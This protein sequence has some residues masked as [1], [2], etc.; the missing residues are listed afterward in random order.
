M[1][2][3]PLDTFVYRIAYFV[4]GPTWRFFYRIRVVGVENFPLTGP[5]V[6]ACNHRAMTDPF[7]LGSNAPRQIHYMAK[8]ELWKFKPLAWAMERFGTFPVNRGEVDR[9]AIKKAIEILDDGEVLGLFPE[10]HCNKGPGL[11]DLRAGVSL[12]SLREGVVTVPAIMRGTDLAFKHGIPHFP[13]IDIIFGPPIEMPGPD[14]PRAERANFVTDR[15]RE[16]LE[17]LLATPVE[18]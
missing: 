6:V 3:G 1:Q 7:F 8:V 2:K 16:T 13:K 5:V 18:R 12:F 4:L 17:N 10:G 14:T 15:V 9:T 11:A